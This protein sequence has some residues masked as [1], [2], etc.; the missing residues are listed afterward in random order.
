MAE[1]LGYSKATVQAIELGK[2]KLSDRLAGV[3]SLKTGINLAWLLDNDVIKPPVDVK[4]E[5]YTKETFEKIQA[6]LNAI[7]TD[8]TIG[9]DAA[10]HAGGV[11]YG[12]LLALILRAYKNDNIALCAYKLAK[13]FDKLEEDFG[14]TDDDRNAVDFETSM[15]IAIEGYR[16]A[17]ADKRNLPQG[18]YERNKIQY[19]VGNGVCAAG[20][21]RALF[22]E[23]K[24][25]KSV[26]QHPAPNHYI[27]ES[28]GAGYK[29]KM[30]EDGQVHVDVP[31]KKTP[32]P[33][34]AN[35]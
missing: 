30:R 28:P 24:K 17:V 1:V 29:T 31:K 9:F 34:K 4:G 7:K 16:L 33:K 12:R 14:V 5:P 26:F 15:K 19:A 23:M 25:K 8:G 21:G 18:A 20:F 35:R 13:T 32:K 2:L 27:F 6:S 3:A 11:N 10:G 22:E